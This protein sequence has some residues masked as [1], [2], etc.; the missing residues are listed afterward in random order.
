[1]QHLPFAGETPAGT[2]TALLG[3]PLLLFLLPRMRTTPE[4]QADM[5]SSVRLPT[6][7]L[8]LIAGLLALIL[9]VVVAMGFGRGAGGWH[10]IASEDLTELLA[11][12]APRVVV[13]LSAG[14]LLAVAGTLMQRMTGNPMAAPEVLGISGGASFG[15]LALLLLSDGFD[16]AAML[17]A[18]LAGA[19]LALT[20][21]VL[22]GRRNALSPSRLLLAGVAVATV[23][24]AFAAL[25]LASG[26]PRTG[27]LLAWLSGSTYRATPNDAFTA[28]AVAVAVLALAP[29]TARWLDIVP[30]GETAARGLGLR[31]GR[32]R[33][34]LLALTALATAT[35]T[36]VIG[37]LSFVGLMAPHLARMLGFRRAVPQLLASAMTG[38]LIL[39]AADWAGRTLIF[40]WQVPAGLIAAFVGGPY[41]M[42]LMWKGRQ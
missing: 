22:V 41:F 33:A 26:D 16:R 24:S 34:I 21:V 23:A 14:V 3:A 27:F 18:A 13:A 19:L 8:P 20:I 12:R 6:N 5:M 38:G 42:A 31:L 7:G 40:P 28:A 9:A 36:L 30:L 29:L 32:V 17:G 37:P 11:L 1:V 35:A 15:V 39:V 2:A 4:R 10:W 25:L